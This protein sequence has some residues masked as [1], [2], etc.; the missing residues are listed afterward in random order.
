MK[1]KLSKYCL[2]ILLLISLNTSAQID[3]AKNPG[4]AKSILKDTLDGN[5]DFS[6]FLIE[7]PKGF[8]PVPFIIT[9]P[10]LGGF[11]LAV[12]PMF[13]KAKKRPPR[14]QGYIPPDITAAFGMYTINKSWML[15]GIRIG[16]IPAKGIKY[17]VAV[18]AG[19]LNLSF[20]RD[21]KNIGEKEFEFNIHIVPVFLSFSKRV[22]KQDVYLG[23][24]YLF[25]ANKLTALFADSLPESIEST[26]FSSKIGS[27][28]V[29]T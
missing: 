10:A 2:L 16:S 21:I 15:G 11:G 8:I 1:P 13:L 17:R 20:Y 24:Q 29:F 19:D 12:V 9:E 6:R 28:G 7:D 25:A 22:I 5:L 3:T 14:F 23:L 27:L 18:G 4:T 26:S